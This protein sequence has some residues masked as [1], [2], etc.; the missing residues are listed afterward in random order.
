MK[1]KQAT[2]R[3]SVHSTLF[4]F[5]GHSA[6]PS[7]HLYLAMGV[8]NS[9]VNGKNTHLLVGLTVINS[10]KYVTEYIALYY[11][12]PNQSSINT[13]K[14]RKTLTYL[15]AYFCP[16]QPITPFLCFFLSAFSFCL[17]Q[18]CPEVIHYPPHLWSGV[19]L[20]QWWSDK[21]KKE[22]REDGGREKTCWRCRISSYEKSPFTLHMGTVLT[23]ARKRSFSPSG[24]NSSIPVLSVRQTFRS[25]SMQ[26]CWQL[27]QRHCPD[28]VLPRPAVKIASKPNSLSWL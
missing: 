25:T 26:N 22:W 1:N 17:G 7:L 6:T 11:H 5:S 3:L 24:M 13:T 12:L 16:K 10:H 23:V 8:L 15:H 20:G 21:S 19:E 27:S 4:Q 28:T 14:Q 18:I 9:P 2:Y